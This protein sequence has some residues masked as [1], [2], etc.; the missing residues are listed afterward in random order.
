[1]QNF[2]SQDDRF[3][4]GHNKNLVFDAVNAGGLAQTLEWFF[5]RLVTETE[6]AVM[7]RHECFRVE[8][9]ECAH[10]LFRI[11]V[12]F[13]G[14]RRIV[15]ADRQQRD[16]DVVTFTDFLESLEI[17]GVAAVKNGTAVSADDKATK[18][19]MSVSEKARAPMMRR[20]KRHAQRTELDCLP[21]IE[22]VH[23]VEP[24]AMDQTSDTDRNDNR[25][26]GCD[27]PQRSAIE[28]IKM[29][30]RDEHEID[31]RQMMNM[32]ARLLQSL[33]HAQPHRPNRID[34][35]IGVVR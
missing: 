14:E 9:I 11:H 21:F 31:R 18:A 12:H 32:K 1:R 23:N 29:R 30:V 27:E 20:R 7:H 4:F 13:A 25:L 35:N 6:T 26:I 19:T 28:M 3:S 8:F 24:E 17:S 5:K 2:F 15:S 10:G 16:L 34:Q 22:L 33:D